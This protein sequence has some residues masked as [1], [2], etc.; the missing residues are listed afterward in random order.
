MGR[1]SAPAEPP[2]QVS[3]THASRRWL[4]AGLG[5]AALAL[6]VGLVAHGAGSDP[7]GGGGH[8]GPAAQPEL[9][10]ADI[11]LPAQ[12]YPRPGKLE[13]KWRDALR[14]VERGD[15]DGAVEKAAQILREDPGD[16]QAQALHDEL[17]RRGAR[18]HDHDD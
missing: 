6:V 7:H 11:V 5:A 18:P 8:P 15:L 14:K 17:V 1:P 4:K 12:A 3:H 16:V 13:K 10:A 9:P 2:T